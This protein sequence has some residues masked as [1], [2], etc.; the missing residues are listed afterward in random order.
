MGIKM[1]QEEIKKVEDEINAEML[2][3]KKREET[4][5]A[6]Q[7]QLRRNL[8]TL[9][10]RQLKGPG[11]D[12]ARELI[13]RDTGIIERLEGEIAILTENIAIKNTELAAK[14]IAKIY[15][16]P[17][18]FLYDRSYKENSSVFQKDN[19]NTILYYPPCGI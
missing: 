3:K 14:L 7:G 9:W 1:L 4:M 11:F 5:I 10:Q 13:N 12:L 18:L 17:F 19:I 15:K 16:S 2:R 6:L 8:R